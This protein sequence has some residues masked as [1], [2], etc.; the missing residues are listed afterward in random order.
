MMNIIT[1]ST[2]RAPTKRALRPEPV[3][4]PEIVAAERL[5]QLLGEL[6]RRRRIGDVEVDRAHRLVAVF[7]VVLQHRQRHE[8]QAIVELVAFRQEAPSTS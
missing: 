6:R 3:R 7:E 5:A 1:R 8:D 2:C 4:H